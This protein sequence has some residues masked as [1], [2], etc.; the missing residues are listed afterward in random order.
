MATAAPGAAGR[1]RDQL[2]RQRKRESIIYRLEKRF[3]H[4]HEL[5]SLAK[6]YLTSGD[7]AIDDLLHMPTDD[8]ASA[9]ADRVRQNTFV[10]VAVATATPPALPQRTEHQEQPEMEQSL[11]N[12]PTPVSGYGHLAGKRNMDNDD[13]AKV[14]DLQKRYANMQAELLKQEEQRKR[15][16]IGRE[17]LDQMRV[18]DKQV[19]AREQ[20]KAAELQE[21]QQRSEDER[22]R[23]QEE[24]V[25][26]QA[27]KKEIYEVMTTMRKMKM[28]AMARERQGRIDE[29]NRRLK[30][31]KKLHKVER[32]KEQSE[33]E[34]RLTQFADAYKQNEAMNRAKEALKARAREEDVARMRAMERAEQ[35]AR[36]RDEQKK[37]ERYEKQA[38]MEMVGQDAM[39]IQKEQQERE[40]QY[41]LHYQR[42]RDQAQD[43]RVEQ[44]KKQRREL[45]KQCKSANEHLLAE[46]AQRMEQAREANRQE[47]QRLKEQE[48]V[49]RERRR[50]QQEDR[51]HRQQSYRNDLQGQFGAVAKQNQHQ[52][53]DTE[54]RL[55]STYLHASHGG[56]LDG[57]LTLPMP[58]DRVRA[59][60]ARRGARAVI[61]D[62]DDEDG[63][64][65]D[66]DA[67]D[68]AIEDG[69][70]WPSDP[71]TGHIE[72]GNEPAPEQ[73]Y[74]KRNATPAKVE[75]RSRST[76][77]TR[78]PEREAV[79]QLEQSVK[80]DF[81]YARRERPDLSNR[82]L[83][84]PFAS[85]GDHNVAEQ[86]T[87]A[88][89]KQYRPCMIGPFKQSALEQLRAV[90]ST[91]TL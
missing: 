44:E 17:L 13:W 77:M 27:E 29:D 20:M 66:E 87:H 43:A 31:L 21:M 85:D 5:V 23:Q 88:Y 37:R 2:I 74:Q 12:G 71:T 16:G 30:E 32:R 48:A 33:R 24:S 53:T 84:A 4:H 91:T 41:V 47:R 1:Q 80:V 78:P 69:Y 52:M 40:M 50:Q 75:T 56:T 60:N 8:A 42:M 46:R 38:K 83:H 35:E 64:D 79:D 26:K 70:I 7:A 76:S 51:I 63:N 9:V 54:R 15:K 65:T 28:D 59:V 19:A 6:D 61:S 81:S 39:R 68:A 36:M 82:Y 14:I 11:T 90:S 49:D 55:N 45:I 22:R 18:H 25:R 72:T 3:G 62:S 10:D 86:F 34:A 57:S 67:G 58:Y 73:Q 89:S